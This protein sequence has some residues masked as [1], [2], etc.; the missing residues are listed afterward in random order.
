MGTSDP[1]HPARVNV[2]LYHEKPHESVANLGFPFWHNQQTWT[3]RATQSV[4]APQDGG[5]HKAI[6][7]V[8]LLN[9][10][11]ML[12]NSLYAVLNCGVKT[13]KLFMISVFR[14]FWVDLKYNM[15]WHDNAVVPQHYTSP[16][17]NNAA[18]PNLT[19]SLKCTF[20]HISQSESAQ[21]LTSVPTTQHRRKHNTTLLPSSGSGGSN[22][23]GNGK[24]LFFFQDFE[25]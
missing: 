9:T 20:Q 25:T 19:I 8:F 6:N 11:Q 24:L 14:M 17:K 3:R 22:T 1:Q 12:E 16:M 7:R 18:S 4:A 10:L 15:S 13:I 23:S 2:F 5:T 21:Q